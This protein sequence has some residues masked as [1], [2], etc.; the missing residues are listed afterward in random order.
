MTSAKNDEE[1]G[2]LESLLE[3]VEA[4]KDSVEEILEEVK[5]SYQL[6]RN[7]NGYGSALDYSYEDD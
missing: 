6:L 2:I 3:K 7:H 5:D 4:I 1:P